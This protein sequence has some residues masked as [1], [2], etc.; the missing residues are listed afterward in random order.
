VENAVRV[1]S[2]AAAIIEEP[3]PTDSME[4]NDYVVAYAD[5]FDGFGLYKEKSNSVG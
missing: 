1:L 2:E 4:F 3:S 5:P